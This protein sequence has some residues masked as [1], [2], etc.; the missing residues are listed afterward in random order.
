MK[1]IILLLILS[2]TYCGY[3]QNK[4]DLWKNYVNKKI[5]SLKSDYHFYDLG[6]TITDTT[7]CPVKIT[8]YEHSI[9]ITY[10]DHLLP[11][12]LPL[13]DLTYNIG[14]CD[15]YI[16]YQGIIDN[17][18]NKHERYITIYYSKIN[19]CYFLEIERMKHIEIL[20]IK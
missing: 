13:R 2:F 9:R 18:P 5:I 3:S 12:I 15:K 6:G 8:L 10:N 17:K 11:T 7:Y 14:G 20:K 1:T 19:D 16:I 4:G